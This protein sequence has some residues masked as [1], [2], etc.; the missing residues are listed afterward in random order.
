MIKGR[1]GDLSP[2]LFGV[3]AGLTPP[4]LFFSASS[5]GLHSQYALIYGY[6]LA[7]IPFYIMWIK[8]EK[9][10]QERTT[11]LAILTLAACVR[12]LSLT[13]PPLLSEDLWRYIW[14]GSISW[15]HINPYT[16][17]PND[18]S[19]DLLSRT[20]NLSMVRD[21]IG[22][23]EI[24]TIYPP[25]AQLIFALA[26]SGGP[27]QMMMRTMMIAGDLIS[28]FMIWKLAEIRKIH[29]GCSALYAFLPLACM[30]SSIGG[31]VDSVGI[32]FLLTGAYFSANRRLLLAAISLTFA[33]G[34]K[35]APLVL[36]IFLFRQNKRLF[37][38]LLSVTGAF[39]LWSAIQYQT[40]PKGL[41]AFAHKWR[42]NDGLFGL[43]YAV[44]E[45]SI[46]VFSEIIRTSPWATKIVYVLVGGD[47]I[48][49][50]TNSQCAFA[51]S[52]I[53]VLFIL[54]LMTLWTLLKCTNLLN[55]WWLFMGTLLLIS[56]M[57]HPW[58]LVWVLPICCLA[59]GDE[60]KRFAQAFIV[61]GLVCWLAYLPRPQYLETGI[62]TE[63]AW[64]K[65]LEY[66]PVWS[67][68]IMAII[69][70]F[71]TNRVQAKRD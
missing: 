25:G 44:S 69:G 36:L 29:P 2:L 46:P 30:E 41:V 61:W 12:F 1:Y 66:G 16:Y 57:V 14:D 49:P 17:A 26:T 38:S 58:Y 23:G 67:L 31:H 13:V 70:H 50:L 4:L 32:A 15:N 39:I 56:P 52:K 40:Y 18:P 20:E 19:L 10:P 5:A 24:P 6:G 62:W 68:L 53:C 55:A 7:G 11:L 63:Q 64:I 35:L 28:I 8:V 9:L 51:L 43:I 33:A 45:M 27:S 65:V 47:T 22:H 60:S 71:R 42:G 37:W 54:G 59:N 48:N 21:Q 34:I 3:L